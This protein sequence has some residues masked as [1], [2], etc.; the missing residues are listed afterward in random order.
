MLATANTIDVHHGSLFGEKDT[1][2]VSKLDPTA[3]TFF[4]C[5]R[6]HAFPFRQKLC[7][8]C[9]LLTPLKGFEPLL[10]VGHSHNCCQMRRTHVMRGHVA[11]SSDLL[12]SCYNLLCFSLHVQ[13][14]ELGERARHVEQRD[15]N[16]AALVTNLKAAFAWL[17][18]I[19]GNFKIGDSRSEEFLHLGC[20]RLKRT[21]RL[22]CLNHNLAS[23]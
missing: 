17:F 13:R 1:S 20:S 23:R 4:I 22:A 8:A 9:T 15:K 6:S 3:T 11:S 14:L 10:R 7:R 18:R 16:C 12:E 21:S 2:A 5:L 19:D